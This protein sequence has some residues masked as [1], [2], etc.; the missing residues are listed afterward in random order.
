MVDKMSRKSALNTFSFINI[1]GIMMDMNEIARK[2]TERREFFGTMLRNGD[3][4]EKI[5]AAALDYFDDK[6]SETMDTIDFAWGIELEIACLMQ[7]KYKT[8]RA[9]VEQAT[10][11]AEIVAIIS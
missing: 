9:E 1:G 8:K 3:D 2:N 7:K 10:T 4:I 11:A 6:I 5:R